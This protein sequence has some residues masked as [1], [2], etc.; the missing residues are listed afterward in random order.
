MGGSMV[1][2]G[3]RKSEEAATFQRL[4]GKAHNGIDGA[5]IGR[6]PGPVQM[7][8]HRTDFVSVGF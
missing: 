3:R 5:V 6:G 7:L 8:E 1:E 2:E 4:S